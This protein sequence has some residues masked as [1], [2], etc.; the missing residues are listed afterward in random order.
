MH[1]AGCHCTPLHT[2]PLPKQSWAPGGRSH[3]LLFT[4]ET[5]GE[6]SQEGWCQP[7]LCQPPALPC[8]GLSQKMGVN[9]P[10]SVKEE[11]HTASVCSRGCPSFRS[12]LSQGVPPA[13]KPNRTS[14]PDRGVHQH[15]A[16]PITG[17]LCLACQRRGYPC[18]AAG[19]LRSEGDL[20]F[21]GGGEGWSR[22][23]EGAGKGPGG[24]PG[25]R[26]KLPVSVQ[27][28]AWPAQAFSMTPS[29][30]PRPQAA[31][32]GGTGAGCTPKPSCSAASP[33]RRAARGDVELPLGTLTVVGAGIGGL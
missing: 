3:I 24:A 18:P 10:F 2:L 32:L 25:Q 23:G 30:S 12:V 13:K 21:A 19:A 4:L 16:M 9:N 29:C 31:G 27:T 17:V 11:Q 33:G 6:G 28:G 20:A 26:E 14:L 15:P 8:R 1:G 7:L 22:K 5:L